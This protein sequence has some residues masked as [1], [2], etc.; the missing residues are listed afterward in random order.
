M[1]YIR[2]FEVGR[3]PQSSK[4]DLAI[5]LR[6][7]KNGP[8]V[9][10]RIRLP[11][12]VQSALRIAVLA[13]PGSKAAKDASASGATLVGEEDL[14][15]QIKDGKTDFDRLIC[16]IDSSP[17]LGKYNV[18]R[19][20]GPKGL[21]PSTKLGTIVKDCGAAVKGMVGAT[22]YREKIGVVRCAVGQ[23]GFGPDEMQKNIREF[24][25]SVRKDIAGLGEVQGGKGKEVHEVVSLGNVTLFSWAP[26]KMYVS[27]SMADF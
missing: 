24:V 19:I 27:V 22:E 9:R 5:R 11:H 21:M 17:K 10:N 20:L 23:L 15:E 3:P 14:L 13:P 1:R 2:A 6:S 8:V 18:G 4:Y 7:L 25:G 12:P 26:R 16:H